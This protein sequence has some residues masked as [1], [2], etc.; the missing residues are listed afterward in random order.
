[1]KSTFILFSD[2]QGGIC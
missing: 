1:L 2:Q